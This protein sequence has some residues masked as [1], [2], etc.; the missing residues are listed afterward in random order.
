MDEDLD[1]T[2]IV[3]GWIGDLNW[4]WLRLELHG[5]AEVYYWVC[6][7]EKHLDLI[8]VVCHW[9]PLCNVVSM[10]HMNKIELT[11][12]WNGAGKYIHTNLCFCVGINISYFDAYYDCMSKDDAASDTN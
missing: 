12:L 6:L 1:L 4:W 2:M 11:V 3:C 8:M 10:Q 7:S 5:K 9:I